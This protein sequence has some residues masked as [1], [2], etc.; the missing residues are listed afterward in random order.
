MVAACSWSRHWHTA[1]AADAP[2]KDLPGGEG[3]YADDPDTRVGLGGGAEVRVDAQVQLD[4][5]AGEPQAAV[6][7]E[8]GGLGVSVMPSTSP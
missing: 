7:G 4:R 8:A 6:G 1:G 5:A 2:V 3:F